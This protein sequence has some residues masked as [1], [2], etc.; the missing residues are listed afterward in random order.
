MVESLLDIFNIS[1][2]IV[3]YVDI[4]VVLIKLTCGLTIL[5]MFFNFIGA[6]I[7]NSKNSIW[8]GAL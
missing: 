2:D 8:R 5:K 6:M 4:Y 1:L 7:P 3:N